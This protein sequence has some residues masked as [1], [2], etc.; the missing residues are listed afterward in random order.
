MKIEEIYFDFDDNSKKKLY[1]V[2][3]ELKYYYAAKLLTCRFFEAKYNQR[4]FTPPLLLK[5][6]AFSCH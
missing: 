4:S 3:T 2:P 6:P 5:L 1:A